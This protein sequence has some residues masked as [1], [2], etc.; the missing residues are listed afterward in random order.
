M[1]GLIQN[2]RGN[3]RIWWLYRSTLIERKQLV[4]LIGPLEFGITGPYKCIRNH[5]YECLKKN[6]WGMHLKMVFKICE[7]MLYSSF[8]V[9][10]LD[11]I[12]HK[13]NF[14]ILTLFIF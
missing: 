8:S 2:N 3:D 4:L 7:G 1:D 11:V 6:N 14:L 13:N 5:T 10:E 9:K 12:I